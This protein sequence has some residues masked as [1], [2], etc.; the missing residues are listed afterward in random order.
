M[1][2]PSDCDLFVLSPFVAR[3]VE[4]DGAR[5]VPVLFAED[6]G[7]V[8]FGFFEF[9]AFW[10]GVGEDL[11]EEEAALLV[12]GAEEFYVETLHKNYSSNKKKRNNNKPID[13]PYFKPIFI[14]STLNKG[15]QYNYEDR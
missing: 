5:F 1:L 6:E 4:E 11:A 15:V 10:V 12:E 7:E 2:A 3:S 9:D 14:I 8:L 13:M